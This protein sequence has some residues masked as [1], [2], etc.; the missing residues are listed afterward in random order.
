MVNKI[1]IFGGTGSLG[2]VLISRIIGSNF[3]KHIVTFSRCEEKSVAIRSMY[4]GVK[5]YIGD[6]RDVDSVKKCIAVEKPDI[7]INAV[8]LK[9]VPECED[10]PLEAIKTNAL[11]ARNIV[12]AIEC[13]DLDSVRCL[14]IS[15][16]KVV[17]AVST[18]GMT[19]ALQERL[20]MRGMGSCIFNL[21]RYCNVLESRGSVIP[22]FKKQLEDGK[23]LTITNVNMTRF[24]MSL[25]ES[26]DL[27]FSALEDQKGKQIFIPKVKSAKLYDLA[28]LLIEMSGKNVDIVV[29][30]IRPGEKIHES[31]ISEEEN[32]RTEET[33]NLLIVH[34]ILN[35]HVDY[36][37]EFLKKVSKYSSNSEYCIMNKEELK[38]FLS[39]RKIL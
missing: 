13:S 12:E 14:A 21:V 8:A 1:L 6:I 18:Y 16:D 20:W 38:I 19:K 5:A 35:P 32:R 24:F 34:D 27:I 2:K 33:E 15:T 28:E 30:G 4:S 25:D 37:S 23:N 26:V 3:A 29:S 36:N 39:E 9:N 22:F 10:Y 17:E 31:L 11:G 7:I